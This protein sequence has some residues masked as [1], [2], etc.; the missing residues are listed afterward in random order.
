[1]AS[2]PRRDII[3]ES[4]VGIYHCTARCVRRAFLCGKDPYTGTDYDHRKTW[5]CRTS[6]STSQRSGRFTG[7][8]GLN[9]P[10]S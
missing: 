8:M 10:F 5:T 6:T 9:T 2:R 1:M 4:V 7:S 3:D